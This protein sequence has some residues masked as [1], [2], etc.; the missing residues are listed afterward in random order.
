M[1]GPKSS[2]GAIREEIGEPEEGEW[3]ESWHQEV[4]MN[5]AQHSL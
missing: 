1:G 2:S 5:V 4:E 3:A